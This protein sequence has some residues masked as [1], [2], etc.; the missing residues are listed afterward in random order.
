MGTRRFLFNQW[1]SVAVTSSLLAASAS[2]ASQDV[3]YLETAGQIHNQMTSVPVGAHERCQRVGCKSLAMRRAA[4]KPGKIFEYND[5]AAV[6]IEV[7]RLIY[8]DTDAGVYKKDEYWAIPFDPIVIRIA[9]GRTIEVGV[10]RGDCDD[11]ALKK[12]SVLINRGYDPADL[13]YAVLRKP[14]KDKDGNTFIEGHLV[15]LARLNG[16]VYVLDNLN[17]KPK[18]FEATLKDNYNYIKY[19]FDTITWYSFKKDIVNPQVSDVRPK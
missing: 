12:G 19:S 15:L 6:N 8:P 5:L 11:Y 18:S 7:N 3:A 13:M 4:F 16:A 1:A 10:R 2:Q 14:S 9:P 17:E